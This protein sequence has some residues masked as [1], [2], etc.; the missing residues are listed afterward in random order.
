MKKKKVTFN[1][2]KNIILYYDNFILYYQE[3]LDIIMNY[4]FY[5]ITKKIKYRKIYD[6]NFKEIFDTIDWIDSNYKDQE[7]DQIDVFFTIYYDI[8][9]FSNFTDIKNTFINYD[10]AIFNNCGFHNFI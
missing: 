7:F 3:I 10:F 5:G 9:K 4:F 8:K 2:N 1:E 6:Y